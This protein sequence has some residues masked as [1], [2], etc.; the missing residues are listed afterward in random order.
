MTGFRN[1]KMTFK[2]NSLVLLMAVFMGGIGYT[3]YAYYHKQ[4]SAINKMYSS[5][6][7]SVKLLNE[8]SANIKA[9]EAFTFE[10]LLAP[11][12]KIREQE[13]LKSI[14]KADEEIDTSL[15]AYA[16]IAQNP[17]E[18]YEAARLPK[19]KEALTRYRTER[20]KAFDTFDQGIFDQ[21]IKQEAYYYY[22]NNALVNLDTIHIVLTDLIAYNNQEAE[23]TI[24]QNNQDFL[25]ASK[26][27]FILPFLAVLLA[28]TLGV[29]VARLIAKPLQAML[30]N[31]QEVARGNLV[32]EILKIRSSDE[33]G[34]LAD[35]FNSMT[36][37]LRN[38]VSQVS[39]SSQLV[40]ESAEELQAIT[41]ENSNAAGQIVSTMAAAA[42]DTEK[43]ASAV[44]ET[45]VAIE[46]VSASTQQIAATSS[47][48]ADLTEKTAQTTKDG[49][50]AVDQ[51][52][53]QMSIIGNKT[54]QVQ[55]AIE[56]LTASNQQ[57]REI[58]TFISGIAEETNLLALNAAIEAARAGEQGRGFAVVA[59]EVRK[60]AEQSRGASLQISFLIHKNEENI[61][62]A[63]SAMNAAIND[64]RTGIS[65]VGEAG[66]AFAAI[67]GHVDEVSSQVREISSTIQQ[68][69]LGNQQIVGSVQRISSFS[70]DTAGR[71][72]IVTNTIEEQA[73]SINHMAGA[74]QSMAAIA[75]ELQ[76]AV[77]EFNV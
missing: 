75:Q 74:S 40:T 63:V 50:K 29:L 34:Q 1:L 18:A 32:V 43:Q 60:L 61:D 33:V 69:A 8:A 2:I 17:Y 24:A 30:K 38:L 4:N 11:I 62:S 23:K 54:E 73:A 71:V 76:A 66:Q 57:V 45:S 49:Q 9:T 12:E 77:R 21:K 25:Q 10:M 37:N 6:L 3:G 39:H 44:N 28:L 19:L 27:L 13:I 53:T 67:T 68:V 46:Q 35:A 65:V 31:M 36:N 70:Q 72:Q 47:S 55:L 64:V 14:R 41:T 15:A 59:A 56:N 48:V 52:I 5:S 51:V 20:Q 42:S 58:I 7:T 16:S 22:S 26:I